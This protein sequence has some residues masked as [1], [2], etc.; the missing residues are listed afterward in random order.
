MKKRQLAALGLLCSLLTGCGAQQASSQFF[1]M[2]TIM[3]VAAEGP[4]AKKAVEGAEQDINRLDKL[5]SRTRTDSEIYTLNH[6]NGAWT[7]V[8]YE[9][10]GLIQQAKDIAVLTDGAYD[11]T[12]APLT[13]LWGIGTDNAHVPAQTEIDAA[14]AHVDYHSIE[15]APGA[16]AEKGGRVRLVNGA[17]LDLGGIAKGYAG[18]CAITPEDTDTALLSLGGN[19][20]AF[21]KDGNTK[22]YKIGVADP[23]SPAEYL[24]TVLLTNGCVVTTGDY[25]RYFEQDGVR[26]HHVFDPRTGYP[27]QTDL[28]SA[29]V[30]QPYED[31]ARADG[32]STAL[33]V[34]GLQK[35]LDFCDKNAVPAIF[36]T[37][38]KRVILSE[39]MKKPQQDGLYYAF[40]EFV[41]ADKGYTY[42][43]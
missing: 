25:E 21:S 9:T 19:V 4:D 24:A 7:T 27:A 20:S 6:A 37:R 34:M 30:V 28:R 40:G 36:I 14:L 11:P 38:D 42:A 2:N 16:D 22:P 17:E 18:A 10:Y 15:L 8:S 41:G 23:D 26:Y 3:Q 43:G 32:L 33:F 35:A 12:V 29:T 1:A 31:G 5:L 39:P 13:D